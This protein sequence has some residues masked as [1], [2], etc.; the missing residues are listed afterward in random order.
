ML[1]F[2]LQRRL[3]PAALSVGGLAGPV[4]D[5]EIYSFRNPTTAAN[6]KVFTDGGFG[7][8]SVAKMESVTSS[9]D[10][11]D[12][13]PVYGRFSGTI[14]ID[15]PKNRPDI[16]RSGFAAWRMPDPGW[17]ILGKALYNVEPYSF[18]AMR[19]KADQSRY[20]V[21]LQ[22]DSMVQSDLFQHR[23]FA[24]TPG[25]WETLYVCAY[26]KVGRRRGKRADMERYRSR[27]S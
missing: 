3:T 9:G 12:E 2:S 11:P 18:L 7:G 17:T 19:V 10:S 27:S 16:E 6:T 13:P 14:S 4:P 24:K 5:L 15:L 26:D 22:V 8:F 1:F 21:N 25:K 23:L 20:F